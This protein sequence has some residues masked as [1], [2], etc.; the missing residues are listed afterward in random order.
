VTPLTHGAAAWTKAVDDLLKM[1]DARA[2]LAPH[3]Q[4]TTRAGTF[5]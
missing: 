1:D 5:A 3:A 2:L 4:T